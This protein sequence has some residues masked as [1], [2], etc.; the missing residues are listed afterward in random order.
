MELFFLD[1]GQGTANVVLLGGG[2]ALVIDAGRRSRDLL[3]ALK[4]FGVT[5][6]KGLFLS[7]NHDDHVNAAGDLLVSYR[8]SIDLV[9]FLFDSRLTGARF[10]ESLAR[11]I[12]DGHI[13]K[14]RQLKRLEQPEDVTFAPS[15][16]VVRV[17]APTFFENITANVSGDANS[18]SAVVSLEMEG[19]RVIFA[20]DSVDEQ[21]ERIAENEGG[22]VRCHALAV[23]HHAGITGTSLSYLD[24]VEA[25]YGIVSVGS[26]NTFGHPRPEVISR[27]R[28]AGTTILCT[29]ITPQCCGDLESVRRDHPR[30]SYPGCG[31]TRAISLSRSGNSR[32]VPCAGTIKATAEAGRLRLTPLGEH[33]R[34]VDTTVRPIGHPL[35]RRNSV[36]TGSTHDQLRSDSEPSINSA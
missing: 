5:C 34:F 16:V 24:K 7:H 20:G 28:A 22:K 12:R 18:T 21:W 14:H 27:L 29:Q 4:T 31:V 26:N 19:C 10:W 33:Q 30:L 9:F 2:D 3:A 11:E 25:D 8:R 15:G 36:G 17:L 6:I 23:P 32:N 13:D 1:V 35:C